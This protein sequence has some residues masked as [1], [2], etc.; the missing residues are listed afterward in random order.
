M[1]KDGP[2]DVAFLDVMRAVERLT[3][4]ERDRVF[5][6][7]AYLCRADQKIEG[8]VRDYLSQYPRFEHVPV[9]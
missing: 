3:H 5:R 7:A 4:D 1:V 8:T 9:H 6:T 2:V